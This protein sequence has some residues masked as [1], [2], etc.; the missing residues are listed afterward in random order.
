MGCLVE[1][2]GDGFREDEEPSIT[3]IS[4]GTSFKLVKGFIKKQMKDLDGFD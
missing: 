3:G 1:G 4:L 2:K